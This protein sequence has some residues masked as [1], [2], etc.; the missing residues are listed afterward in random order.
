MC[1][2]IKIQNNKNQSLN[3]LKRISN[4]G[5]YHSYELLI[6]QDDVCVKIRNIQEGIVKLYFYQV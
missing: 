1:S 5:G 6:I 4:T 3:T 2:T